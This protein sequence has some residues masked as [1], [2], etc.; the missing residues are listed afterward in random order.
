MRGKG[1]KFGDSMSVTVVFLL[2]L[3]QQISML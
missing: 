2:F 1:K 3:R